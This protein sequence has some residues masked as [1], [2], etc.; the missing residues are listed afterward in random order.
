LFSSSKFS[1][2]F[3][4]TNCGLVEATIGLE[5]TELGLQTKKECTKDDFFGASDLLALKNYL[6]S[7]EQVPESSIL[8]MHWHYLIRPFQQ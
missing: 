2:T 6:E 8:S 4:P 3:Q 5:A 1:S 7:I